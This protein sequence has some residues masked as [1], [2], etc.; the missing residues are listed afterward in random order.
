LRRLQTLVAGLHGQ[1]AQ[2]IK[3]AA[4]PLIS[5][6]TEII[7]V[8]DGLFEVVDLALERFDKWAV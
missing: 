7:Q 1:D 6:L 3:L 4:Q 2:V 8:L 5:V